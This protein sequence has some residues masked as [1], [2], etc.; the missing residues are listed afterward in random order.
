[1]PASQLGRR[2]RKKKAVRETIRKETLRLI[3]R[4][5]VEGLTIDAICDCVDIAK[6]TFYNYYATKHELMMELCE[7]ELLQSTDKLIDEL[8]A[9]GEPF[10]QQLVHLVEVF[11]NR[12]QQAGGVERQLIAYS[13]GA[14][15]ANISQGAGQLAFI[16][17]SFLRM[18]EHNRDALKPGLTPAFCAEMTVGMFNAITLNWVHNADYDS[19]ARYREM[20]AFI[21][22]SMLVDG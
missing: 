21:R 3:G 20:L 14:M 12:N 6:K 17:N 13:V 7:Q 4:H 15:A 9:C 2:E 8:L 19:E 16:N 22:S 5:G 18:Y 1:M 10:F 11:I